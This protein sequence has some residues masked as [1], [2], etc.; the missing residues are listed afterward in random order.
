MGKEFGINNNTVSLKEITFSYSSYKLK[1]PRNDIKDLATTLIALLRKDT[2]FSFIQDIWKRED[3]KKIT[4]EEFD[5][6]IIWKA[7]IKYLR[8]MF[9]LFVF[10]LSIIL[11]TQ[12]A[13]KLY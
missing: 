4:S 11:V 6:Y 1:S 3:D 8:I 7:R 12:I 13:R 5:V 10:F 2:I 9:F